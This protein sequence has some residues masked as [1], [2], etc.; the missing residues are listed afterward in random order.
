MIK[1]QIKTNLI[2]K[3]KA[4]KLTLFSLL[5]QL[6]DHRRKQGTRHPLQ[7]VL[8]IAIMAIMS[9]AKGP[10][11]MGE[12]GR[13]NKRNLSKILKV[14]QKRIP[15]KST[16]E[17]TIKGLDFEEFS[18]IFST[19]SSQSM[20]ISKGEWFS[21]DGKS[22]RGTVTHS[23]DNMQNFLS[24]ISVFSSKKKQVLSAK[25]ISSKKESEIPTVRE[26]IKALDL[27]G[28][29]FTIDALHCQ[30]K[31]VKSI[32]ESNNNY[33]IGLKGNQPKLLKQVKKT[34]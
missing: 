15:A 27:E 8:I 11:G 20:S 34:V 3:Q 28:M 14:P 1:N 26:L 25:K 2:M 32:V 22:I 29:V 12:F 6:S 13:N 10:T 19:W 7:I 31:T 16:F 23:N 17:R 9:G 5:G 30:K 24:L 21:L 18:E 33:V 4:E